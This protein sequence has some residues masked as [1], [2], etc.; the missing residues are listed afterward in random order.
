MAYRDQ[1]NMEPLRITAHLR[2][3]VVAD[4][5]LPLDAILLYQANRQALGPEVATL[6]GGIDT[7][8]ASTLPLEIIHPGRK[9]WY[10]ACS[11]AQPQPWWVAEGR[12]HW[13]KRFDQGFAY[14]V[15]F[16]GRRGKVIIEQGRYKAYHMPVFYRVADRVEW[17]CV[18][19]KARVGELLSTMTHLGKKRSQGWGR[20]IQWKVEPWMEDWSVWRDGELTR[21]VP[22]EDVVGKGMFN[23]VHYGLR[24]SYYRQENQMMLAMP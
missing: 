22:A 10:Y 23:F 11:W 2:T 4:R 24:P 21:G 14:M 8:G 15:D 20:V 7:Q 6:P 5:W 18:G 9:I 19:D 13:N 12:D 17:Y 3:G 16:E 1:F